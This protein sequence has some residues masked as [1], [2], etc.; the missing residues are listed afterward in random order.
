MGFVRL[1]FAARHP[2]NP[3][4][5]LSFPSCLASRPENSTCLVGTSSMPCSCLSHNVQYV[6]VCTPRVLHRYKYN[7]GAVTS[8]VK[9]ADFL[10]ELTH[11]RPSIFQPL[12]EILRG[13]LEHH[14]GRIFTDVFSPQLCFL[15]IYAKMQTSRLFALDRS[16]T[17]RVNPQTCSSGL[18]SLSHHYPRM[19]K[20]L[21]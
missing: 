18:S 3:L 10:T 16:S 21:P 6:Q 12:L 8:P 14:E 11:P 9:A 13:F 19:C 4:G 15:E 2:P 17:R 7:S 20:G 1:G 5:S